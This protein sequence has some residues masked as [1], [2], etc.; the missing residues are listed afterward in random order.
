M[1]SPVAHPPDA[2][3]LA[4]AVFAEIAEALA[5][6]AATD[7]ETLIDLRSLPLSPDDLVR[8]AEWLGQGE[9]TCELDVA[10]RSEVRE[11]GFSGVW[12]IRHYGADD[13]VEEIAVTRVPEI[14][15]SHPDDVARAARRMADTVLEPVPPADEEEPSRG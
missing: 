3:A 6:L 10:G 14:L 4:R 1:N 5:R 13:A 12:W 15:A 8:L 9:V 2:P 11:T 7:E